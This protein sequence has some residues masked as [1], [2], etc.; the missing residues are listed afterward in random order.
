MT[1]FEYSKM[2]CKVDGVA[3]KQWLIDHP[4]NVTTKPW[5]TKIDSYGLGGNRAAARKTNGFEIDRQIKEKH[6]REQ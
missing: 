4:D 1:D 6:A 3:L 5:S 2:I